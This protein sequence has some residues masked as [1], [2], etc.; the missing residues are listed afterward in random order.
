M[1]LFSH[2]NYLHF[3]FCIIAGEVHFGL[4][5][6]VQED[7]HLP[8]L[9]IR[10]EFFSL[11]IFKTLMLLDSFVD[12]LISLLH[13]TCN[14]ILKL[15]KKL[16]LHEISV[17]NSISYEIKTLNFHSVRVISIKAEAF[18][19]DDLSRLKIS[20]DFLFGNFVSK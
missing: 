14:L 19:T 16:V 8:F 15:F 11:L 17:C 4:E 12:V 5:F 7:V 9:D 18:L 10:V 1:Q 20:N 13:V 2:K 6:L 3:L